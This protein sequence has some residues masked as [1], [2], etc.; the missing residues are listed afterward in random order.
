M[1]VCAD[2]N[3]VDYS[4]M[5]KRIFLIDSSNG[6]KSLLVEN[7]G[8]LDAVAWAPDGKHIAFISATDVNDPLSG[9][10]YIAEVPNNNKFIELKN[11]SEGFEGDVT[12]V[13]WKDENTILFSSDEGVNN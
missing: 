4:Y 12:H 6:A 1:A 13:I 10:L 5:F 9:T 11:Y 3:V 7:P 8:K 2:K